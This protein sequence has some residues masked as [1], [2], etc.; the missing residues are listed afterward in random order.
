MSFAHPIWL[1]LLVLVPI[2]GAVA[3]L[4]AHLRGKRWKAFVA[5]R[6]RG[7]LLQRTSA[8]PHWLSLVFL[9]LSL[10]LMIIALAGPRGDAGTSS[11][12]IMGR[13][14]LFAL[15]LS[16]SMR[17]SDVKPDRLA[18]AKVLIYE[19][20]DAMPNDRMGLIGFAGNPYLFAPL[21]IDHGAVRETVD[22][23]DETW[24]PS[25]GSDIVAAL[26]LS[27]ETLKKTGIR[28]N[29]LVLI[30]DGE[31][32]DG[33][34][35]E[36]LREAEKSGVYIFTVGVGTE[37]GDFVPHEEFPD[38]KFRDK[39]GQPIISRLHPEVLKAIA[40]ETKGRFA[41][42]G[43]GVDIPA[44]AR[45]A[46]SDLD[47]FELKGREKKVVVEFYQWMLGPA[48][49]C[50]LVSILAA[51]RWRLIATRAAIAATVATSAPVASGVSPDEA[52]AALAEGRSSEAMTEFEDLAKSAK[53]AEDVARFRLGEASS[54]YQ[55]KD[56]KKATDAYSGA[57]LSDDPAVE[58]HAHLGLG[59]ALFHQ[60]WQSLSNGEPYPDPAP[61]DLETFDAMVREELRKWIQSEPP[62]A[63][64]TESFTRFDHLVVN[65]VDAVR[66]FDSA[67]KL[68]PSDE[69]ARQN[70]A[71]AVKYLARLKELLK[72][73]C[74]AA[75]QAI[76]QEPEKGEDDGSPD[77]EGE[78]EPKEKGDPKEGDQKEGD[79]G[80]QGDKKDQGKGSEGDPK[81]EGSGGE[82]KDPKEGEG[83][84]GEKPKKPT[85]GKPD[86]TPRERA[87]R[88][89]GDNQ[90]VQKGPLAPGRNE[91]MRPEKDW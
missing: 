52:K 40:E 29:A 67:L 72:Q 15:D 4:I 50:L 49:F 7:A 84:E 55:G 5:D 24:I 28:N 43:S 88:I 18:Q 47:Q 45:S 16:R 41:V 23:L 51:T 39:D 74:N 77:Q 54:A 1:F 76:P 46:M 60:G 58:R 86:E 69:D 38:N 65:W 81:D 30:S 56:F 21:T 2:F 31:K 85:K 8:L 26:K 37:E 48:L 83:K 33:K 80:D 79:K 44:L 10:A 75:Q 53:R 91:F 78:G 34:L 87:L 11:E 22:Q 3:I 42:A 14:V 57:L 32:H 25:G 6:L 27:I 68:D 20:M 13:N 71:L 64:E 62:E 66:H 63:G 90:D 17:V 73:E 89:L 59:N 19:M 35:D 82:K 61:V 9:L 70:R 12:K 36:V